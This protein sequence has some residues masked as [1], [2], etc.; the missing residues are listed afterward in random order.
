MYMCVCIY[1][2]T[3][4][5]LKTTKKGEK[6]YT[7]HLFSDIL[8]WSSVVW[9]L[10]LCASLPVSLALSI[11]HS[12]NL[13]LPDFTHLSLSQV[14]AAPSKHGGTP[15]IYKLKGVVIIDR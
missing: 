13:S 3:G 8:A 2:R 4:K 10:S 9:P 15:K 12:L 1:L 7:F 5:L 11:S 6:Q 14:A